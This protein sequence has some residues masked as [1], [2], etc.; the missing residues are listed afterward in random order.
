MN[1]WRSIL[2]VAIAIGANT[3]LA[4]SNDQPADA[5]S[6]AETPV[7]GFGTITLHSSVRVPTGRAVTLSDVAVLSGSATAHANI[8]LVPATDRENWQPITVAHVRTA[9]EP[10]P[11]IDWGRLTLSGATCRVGPATASPETTADTSAT[12]APNSTPTEPLVTRPASE[13]VVRD[14]VVARLRQIFDVGPDD[15]R[16]KLHDRDEATLFTPITG[17]IVTVNPTGMSDELPLAVTIYENER[18]ILRD[19]IRAAVEV[20]RTVLIA[21]REVRRGDLLNDDAVF[22]ERRWLGPNLSPASPET[23]LGAAVKRRLRVGEMILAAH[24]EPPIVC[25]RGDLVSIHSIAGGVIVKTTGRAISR[26]RDGEVIEFE[27]MSTGARIRA[28]MSGRGRAV[29]VSDDRE[30]AVTP[31]GTETTGTPSAVSITGDLRRPEQVRR[32]GLEDEH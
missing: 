16:I 7:D 3:A 28:R 30:A 24:I 29:A 25:E 12:T 31:R 18:I 22:A 26:A 17:R 8:V 32:V 5:Q 10:V 19:T 15:I 14:F 23:A 1:R 13:P 6:A 9:L 27:A 21:K 4:Q 20:R 11:G 2:L